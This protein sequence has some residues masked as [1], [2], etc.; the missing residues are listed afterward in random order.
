M[1]FFGS[2]SLQKNRR[3]NPPQNPQQISNQNLGVSPPKSTRFRPDLDLKRFQ[4]KSKSGPNQV[5]A[6]GFG[7]V[8]AGEVGSAGGVPVAPRKVSTLKD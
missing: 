2:F 5:R 1:D 8:G 7:W 3:K 6:E 4:I